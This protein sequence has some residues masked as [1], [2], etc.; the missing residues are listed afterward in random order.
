M[1]KQLL[2][3]TIS[4]LLCA[5][6]L[7]SQTYP[8]Y[9]TG[10]YTGVNG[11][12]FNPANI[13]DNR[14]KWDINLVAINGFAGTDQ[15]GLKLG[16]L[17]NHFDANTLKTKILKG[18]SQV[19]SLDYADL[20]G[21]SFMLSLSPNTS[22]ALTTRSRVFAN[23][24]DVNGDLANAIIDPSGAGI[25]SP[26]ALNGARTITHSTGWTEIGGSVAQ[27]FTKKGSHNF[28]KGSI[29]LKY[30]AGTADAYMTT[31]GITGSLRSA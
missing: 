5:S 28:F 10:N 13:A 4:T 22:I 31:D 21:P 3:V 19:N 9:R 24:K 27:V 23:V 2:I 6:H 1:R 17:T 15:G 8:G 12:F 18:H 7:F 11:A 29:T 30:I 20:L 14:F 25:T 26:I 16:D